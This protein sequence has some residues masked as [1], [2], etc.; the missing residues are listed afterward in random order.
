MESGP[1]SIMIPVETSPEPHLPLANHEEAVGDKEDNTQGYQD[2][3]T[4]FRAKFA[5]MNQSEEGTSRANA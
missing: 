1:S 2:W 4:S 5:E 3:K